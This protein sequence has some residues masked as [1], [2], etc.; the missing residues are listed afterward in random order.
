MRSALLW[1]CVALAF[2]AAGCA[3][4]AQTK[5]A[6]VGDAAAYKGSTGPYNSAGWKPGDQAS[7]DEQMRAR[8]Q[9]GQNEYSRLGGK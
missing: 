7:W 8:T 1:A 3:E 6:G 9:Y 4:K 5:V 2:G